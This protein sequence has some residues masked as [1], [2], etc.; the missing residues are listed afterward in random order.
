MEPLSASGRVSCSPLLQPRTQ[1]Q[2]QPSLLL[3]HSVLAAATPLPFTKCYFLLLPSQPQQLS[4]AAASCVG[5]GRLRRLLVPLPLC[6][7]CLCFLHGRGAKRPLC[8]PGNCPS[9]GWLP[10][11]APM[12]FQASVSPPVKRGSWGPSSERLK[13]TGLGW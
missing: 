5:G 4:S 9:T 8:S 7:L 1:P 3:P 11:R 2:P 6:G 10:Q 13:Q 12:P